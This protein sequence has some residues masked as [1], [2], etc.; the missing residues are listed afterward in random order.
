MLRLRWRAVG[1]ADRPAARSFLST[2]SSSRTHS[3]G[4]G[5]RPSNRLRRQPTTGSESSVAHIYVQRFLDL[6]GRSALSRT[7][8]RTR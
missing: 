3:S 7:C 6:S 8:L 1:Y 5:F 4:V 2:L